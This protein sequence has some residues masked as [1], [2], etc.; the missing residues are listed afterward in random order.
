MNSFKEMDYQDIP[1]DPENTYYDP[2]P[3]FSEENY[4]FSEKLVKL[5]LGQ[6]R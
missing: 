1:T 6:Q 4:S 3:S 5:N 2:N